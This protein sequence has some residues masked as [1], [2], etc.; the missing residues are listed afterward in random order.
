[1]AIFA[2]LLL[3]PWWARAAA[4]RLKWPHRRWTPSTMLSPA[5]RSIAANM[6]AALCALQ[7]AHQQRS[8]AF[9]PHMATMPLS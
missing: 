3:S 9:R 4:A 2:G 6:G 7:L 8:I 1:L 5:T